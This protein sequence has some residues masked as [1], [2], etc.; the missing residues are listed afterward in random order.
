MC[1]CLWNNSLLGISPRV[2]QV[3]KWKTWSTAESI[4]LEGGGNFRRW[5]LAR[6][7]R[8]WEQGLFLRRIF[9]S[10]PLPN[11]SLLHGCHQVNSSVLSYAFLSHHRHRNN[12]A[13]NR[14]LKLL[15]PRAKINLPSFKPFLSGIYH[16][17]ISIYFVLTM[18]VMGTDHANSLLFKREW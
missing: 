11:T 3:L 1:R 8:S 14:G 16:S 2:P 13:N 10:L 15:N 9:C 17:R 4:S 12:G 7:S 5:C 18:Y 6:G